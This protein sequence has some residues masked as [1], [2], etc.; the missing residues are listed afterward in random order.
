MKLSIVIVNYNVVYFLDNC[1]SSVYKAIKNI[2]DVE[3][4]V[5]DNDSVDTSVDM[6]KAK[7]PKVIL[8]ENK[9][10]AG[11]AKANNQA[12]K[13][14]TGEYVL[15]LNPDT[16]VE[17]TTFEKC[18]AFMD[19][20][21]DCGGLGVKMID[22]KGRL[23]KE[24][25]RGFPSPWV[26]FCK[27]SGLI[28]LF[29]HSKRYAG[30]YLGH[31]SYDRTNEVEVLAGAYMML[32]RECL[33]KTGLLDEDYF[34]YGEDI[35]LSYRITQAGYK[36]YYYPDT[37]I[38]HYKGESTKK[39]SLNYV[40]TFFNAMKIFADKHL[41]SKQNKLFSLFITLA[42]W[43]NA[44]IAAIK[45][46][47]SHIAQPILDFV[48]SYAAFYFLVRLWAAA[49][50]HNPDYYAPSYILYVIPCYILVLLTCVYLCGGYLQK[51]SPKRIIGGIF[52]GMVALLVFYSLMPSELRYSRAL[53]LIGGVMILVIMLLIRLLK[54]L[55]ST[56]KLTFCDNKSS[57]YL[58]I[59]DETESERVALMLRSTQLRHEAIYCQKDTAQIADIIRIYG[60][61]EVIFCAKSLS[62]ERIISLMSAMTNTNAHYSIA[63]ES[64][65][66][67]ISSN[68]INT[69]IDIYTISL[70]SISQEENR[71]NK[72]LFD[73]FASFILLIGSP[74]L[75]FVIKHPLR[76]IKNCW[77][78]MLS[79]K[80]LVGY[81]PSENQERLPK[82]KP[83]VLT[84]LDSIKAIPQD[85]AVIERL[86]VMYARNYSIERDFNILIRGIKHLGRR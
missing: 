78:V 65:D 53:I 71:H 44:T 4:F 33:D 10:N 83:C 82:I 37:R 66:C 39:G 43:F 61:N 75:V 3:I 62:Q 38:I 32:R 84:S 6:V 48:L 50:W 68:A 12:I 46:I 34:M 23:L 76:Y 2:P 85:N 49:V 16:L 54:G 64:V 74:I 15:L 67:I 77:L 60:I 20:H 86:N 58:I 26:S 18:L 31:L 35:D 81:S 11:F 8:I 21:K 28:K 79:K 25:K 14:S 59:G 56:G 7:Y 40:Y 63:P 22:G 9:E 72:R 47:F 36:N 27:L 51:T 1:L 41:S 45:R 13:Q 42:I 55:I 69:P 30:Y 57:K 5:V 29:P 70:N 73:L 52:F 24:S 80:T 17:E 19:S